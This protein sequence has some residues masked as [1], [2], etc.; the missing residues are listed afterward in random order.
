MVTMEM[1]ISSIVIKKAF[2]VTL[3]IIPKEG[4]EL[5][6]SMYKDIAIHMSE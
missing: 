1:G 5:T 3:A 2:E 4:W 6:Q